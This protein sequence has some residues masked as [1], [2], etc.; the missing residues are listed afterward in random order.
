MTKEIKN[1][2]RA[3]EKL[4]KSYLY[5][6]PYD[7][8]GWK[9]KIALKNTITYGKAYSKFR[10][11]YGYDKPLPKKCRFKLSKGKVIKY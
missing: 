8:S 6:R 9:T 5:G 4:K 3:C 11:K 1:L 2:E 10:E 7:K